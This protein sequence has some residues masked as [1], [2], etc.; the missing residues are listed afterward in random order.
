MGIYRH[1]LGLLW[2]DTLRNCKL[3]GQ[4]LGTDLHMG[5]CAPDEE[6]NMAFY[7]QRQWSSVISAYLNTWFEQRKR[8]WIHFL[9]QDTIK[10]GQPCDLGPCELHIFCQIKPKAS[11]RQHS[12]AVQ[13]TVAE[14]AGP[15]L[16]LR[17]CHLPVM[18]EWT[19]HSISRCP[20]LF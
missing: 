16:K 2:W 11:E 7:S 19:S 13:S 18:L 5:L 15:D 1:H 3:S 9:P 4:I 14:L 12:M 17:L 6:T 10:L 8:S 20:Q